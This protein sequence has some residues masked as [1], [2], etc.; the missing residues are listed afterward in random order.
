MVSSPWK[1]LRTLALTVPQHEVLLERRGFSA[2]SLDTQYR[3][4]SIGLSFLDGYHAALN[5]K[6]ANAIIE[7]LEAYPSANRGFA[8]EGAAMATWLLDALS[9]FRVGRWKAFMDLASPTQP[10]ITHVGVGWALARLPWTKHSPERALPQLD[11][12][13]GWLAIDGFGFH[14]GYFHTAK[15]IHNPS[16]RPSFSNYANRVFDQGLGRSL[17][18]VEGADVERIATRLISFDAYR[19]ADLWSGVGLACAYAGQSSEDELVC[20]LDLAK[21]HLTHLRQGITFGAEA[22]VRA[23][24]A[25]EHTQRACAIVCD[26]SATEAAT[27]THTTR[28]Q[29]EQETE[30]RDT[31]TYEIWRNRLRIQLIEHSG[32]VLA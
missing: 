25:D 18:F 6:G 29:A 21:H 31:P 11:P 19:H 28:S 12:T 4:E 3:L 26:M 10:Y 22:R 14:E 17:W 13:L 30:L 2:K 20:L 32:K 16:Q 7:T 15:W 23:G 5:D 9:P 24:L 8:Y 1:W 27:L